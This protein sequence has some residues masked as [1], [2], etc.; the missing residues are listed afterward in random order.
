M[1]IQTQI[2]R[3]T[4]EVSSQESMLESLASILAGKTAG[5]GFSIPLP[6]GYAMETGIYTPETDIGSTPVSITLENTYV[7]N[8]SGRTGNTYLFMCAIDYPESTQG[9]YSSFCARTTTVSAE[10]RNCCRSGSSGTTSSTNFIELKSG[11]T[12]NVLNLQGTDTY[13][14]KAGVS[15]MWFVIGLT[16]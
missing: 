10:R 8:A 1:S 12:S 7:W 4:G 14:M 9:A 5:G 2:D 16:A 3:I 6:D 13:K 11:E 15:Y